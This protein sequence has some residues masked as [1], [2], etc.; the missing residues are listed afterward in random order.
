MKS[1]CLQ[2]LAE[3]V[4]VTFRDTSATTLLHFHKVTVL[5]K[6]GRRTL[7]FNPRSI[8]KLLLWHLNASLMQD[9][10][11]CPIFFV[12][13]ALS[14]LH[15]AQH[16]RH[17]CVGAPLLQGRTLSSAKLN[18]K[19]TLNFRSAFQIFSPRPEHHKR[20]GIPNMREP[21]DH[22]EMQDLCITPDAL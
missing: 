10:P 5:Q 9:R 11:F 21:S 6:S 13:N 15:S 1:R 18:S 19:P 8:E 20:R 3:K 7:G 2:I 4:I 14:C 22:Q 17:L 16:K 12:L